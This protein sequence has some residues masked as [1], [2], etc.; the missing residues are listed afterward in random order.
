MLQPLSR[1]VLHAAYNLVAIGA[2]ITI[3]AAAI[4]AQAPHT[5]RAGTAPAKSAADSTYLT[6]LAVVQA[7][8]TTVDLA[9]LRRQF[10]STTFY[11]PYDIHVGERK[12][13]M[14]ARLDAQ[15]VAGA[16]A[17]ADSL[18]AANYLDADAHV[19]AGVSA[20]ARGDSLAAARHFAVARCIM[21]SM[22]STGDGR[23]KDRPLFV[24]SPAEEYSYLGAVGLKRVGSQGLDVCTDGRACDRLEV[25]PRDG[26][27][28][29]DLF[30]DI[31]LPMAHMTRQ[32]KHANKP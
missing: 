5:S 14:W 24:L 1:R 20:R 31:S 21:R 10:A 4:A 17:I 3:G 2:T 12:A 29:F 27:E 30:F 26:G 19:G 16:G 7:G 11:A 6:R 18:L 22:E 15:D 25:A 23:T 28:K 8:D 9:A 32:F 13:R